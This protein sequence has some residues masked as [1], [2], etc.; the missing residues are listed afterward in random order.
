VE[1]ATNSKFTGESYDLHEMSAFAENEV[2]E[3]NSGMAF[4]LAKL[5]LLFMGGEEISKVENEEFGLEKGYK[6]SC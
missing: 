6:G 5:R 3:G 4:Q 1:K 2:V